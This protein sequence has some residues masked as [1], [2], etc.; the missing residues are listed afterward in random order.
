MSKETNNDL[1][2]R[3]LLDPAVTVDWIDHQDGVWCISSEFPTS[4]LIGLYQTPEALPSRRDQILY[5]I[6]VHLEMLLD[7]NESRDEVMECE[8]KLTIEFA[9]SNWGEILRIDRE[10]GFSCDFDTY[11]LAFMASVGTK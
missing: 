8:R 4:T 1:I 10:M 2:Q 11:V 9:R 5:A 6:A 3:W 7:P